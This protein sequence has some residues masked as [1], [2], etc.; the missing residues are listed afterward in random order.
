MPPH[1]CVRLQ[2]VAAQES[3]IGHLSYTG[4]GNDLA[5]GNVTFLCTLSIPEI[6]CLRCSRCPGSTPGNSPLSPDR[7]VHELWMLCCGA[8][9]HFISDS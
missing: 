9:G 1:L 6:P 8:H 2:F 4:R 3:H 5:F 7:S